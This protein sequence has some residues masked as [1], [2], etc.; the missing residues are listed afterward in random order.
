MIANLW[1]D[2]QSISWGLMMLAGDFAK[3]R[4]GQTLDT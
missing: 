3:Q 2:Y 4:I 1:N